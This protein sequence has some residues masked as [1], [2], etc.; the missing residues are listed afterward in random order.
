MN[1]QQKLATLLVRFI[2]L[3]IVLMT[4][5]QPIISAV[6]FVICGSPFRSNYAGVDL[7][8]RLIVG[9]ILFAASK[10]VGRYL[11]KGLE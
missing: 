6:A 2:G 9:A 11:G 5:Y 8:S 10:P 4:L 7:A 3:V 1:Q